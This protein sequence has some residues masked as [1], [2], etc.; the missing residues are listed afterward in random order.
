MPETARLAI[1][2]GTGLQSADFPAGNLVGVTAPPEPIIP[3]DDEIAEIRRALRNPVS[4]L[5][6]GRLA[7]PGYKVS[8]VVSD[9]TRPT[10]SGRILGPVLEE[11]Q[12]AGVVAEDITIVIACGL[13][14]P[15]SPAHLR[16]MLG[17]YILKKYRVINH[18]A[19][20]EAS[21]VYLGKTSDGIPVKINKAVAEAD[22]T[23]SIGAIDPHH[24]AGF[25]GGAKNLLPGVASRETVNAHHVLLMDP[26]TGVGRLDGNRF[27]DQLEEAARIANF[28]FIVNVVLTP[29]KKIAHAVTGDVV[30]AH[31]Q[32]ADFIKERIR[33]P[34]Y[35]KVDLV[36]ASPGGSPRDSD[37]WQTDGKCLTR[38]APVIKDGGTVIVVSECRQGFGDEEFAKLLGARSSEELGAALARGPFSTALA[39][40]YN[41][42]GLAGRTNFYLVTAGI[43]A[44]QLPRIP[45][46]VFPTLEAAVQQA[47]A[48]A[49][50]AKTLVVP[51]AA[52]VLLELRD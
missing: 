7:Q 28:N 40:A 6:L 33:V 41:L 8:V 45:I 1:P 39:K 23:V 12:A 35:G 43:K 2:Y 4:S 52:G 29:D 51:D 50:Q 27:R 42:A 30:A 22:L 38:I 44:E 5:P 46:S 47:L 3:V 48:A 37:L 49:P 31:R 20:D 16:T 24:W 18:L 10:P 13:H 17:E 21:L 25:S 19:D 14:V 15:S 11:L 26:D 32:G 34:V 9:F 36:I